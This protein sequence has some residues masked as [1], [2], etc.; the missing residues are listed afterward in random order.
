MLVKGQRRLDGRKTFCV[1]TISLEPHYLEPTYCVHAS[2]VNMFQ[3]I[4]YKYLV[5]AGYYRMCISRN[6]YRK[7]RSPTAVLSLDMFVRLTG[8]SSL[9][10]HFI[11]LQIGLGLYIRKLHLNRIVCYSII[12]C[13]HH[14]LGSMV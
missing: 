3:N 8:K 14:N 12:N 11:N 13:L 4:I 9:V 1:S 2:S 7:C 10:Y 5:R 6:K